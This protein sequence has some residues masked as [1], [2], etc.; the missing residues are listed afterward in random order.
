MRLVP[1]V[2]VAA[3][4][5]TPNLPLRPDPEPPAG[6]T[7]EVFA[8]RDGTQL[9][10]RH[11]AAPSDQAVAAKPRGVV[12]VMHGLKDYSARYA[13]FATRLVHA[14]YDVYAFDLR[15]HGRSAGPRV[16][17][18][19]WLD[20]IDDLDRFLTAVEA[21]E[22]GR[23]VFLFGH[24]MGGAIATL[25]AIR[26]RPQV[27]GLVLSGPAL[28]VDAPPLVVAG[29]RLAGALAPNAPALGLDNHDF[30]S[31]PAAAKAMDDD[32]LV[33]QPPA[34]ARTAAGLVDGI[35]QIWRE[36]DQLTMPILAL[37]GTADRLTA[38]AGSRWLVRKAPSSDKTLRIYD[39][40]FHD[41]LHE[42]NGK[43][44]ED[45]ILAWLDAQTGEFPELHSGAAATHPP[46][47]SGHLAGDPRELAQALEMSAGIADTDGNAAFAGAFAFHIAKWRPIGVTASL[48]GRLAG[49][50]KALALRPLG[51]AAR[52]GPAAI[53]A[54]GGAAW[55]TG[56][57]LAYAA[58]AW[59]EE[60]AGPLHV[61]LAV[62]WARRFSEATGAAPGSAD[63]LWTGAALR[64]GHDRRY[65]PHLRAGVG[66]V[67]DAGFQWVGDARGFS[68]TAGL[69]LYGAD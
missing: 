18:A 56:S 30:S 23:K 37:H 13:N 69:E 41:L 46:V 65:W 34:P 31:D 25:T 35:R 51:I 42:P 7:V 6:S 67:V 11:W 12:V 43:Q 63:L 48:T 3:C 47:Y 17:P 55:I 32:P 40:F 28:A 15:G 2:L 52:L 61:S 22:P 36:L 60:P 9:L 44:V 50:Y 4:A 16:A 14:G 24:S 64:L 38:P 66:P 54:S 5:H 58:G 53:G 39:G 68:V 27:A 20:Y 29:T 1:F 45:D 49:D 33:S 57:H 10:T 19:H 62:D 59:V 8:A 26:H 21:R